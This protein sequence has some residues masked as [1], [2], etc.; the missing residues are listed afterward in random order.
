MPVDADYDV[1]NALFLGGDAAMIVNGDWELGNYAGTFGD[2]LGIAPI[3][4][5]VGGAWPAALAGRQVPDGADRTRRR[6]RPGCG[7]C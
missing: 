4:E 7:R 2:S 6:T 5:V 1:A 3:P